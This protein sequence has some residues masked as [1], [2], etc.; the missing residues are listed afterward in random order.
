MRQIL[1]LPLRSA[2]S[3]LLIATALGSAA[4]QGNSANLPPFVNCS[5]QTAVT[6]ATDIRI[7]AVG[8]L[9]FADNAQINRPT[10]KDFLPQ[11]TQADLG[12]L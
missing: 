9:V 1:P 4:A 12:D 7:A 8:D 10:F 11:L 6:D 3:G 5:A 2:A